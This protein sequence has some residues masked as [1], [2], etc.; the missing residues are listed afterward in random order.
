[1]RTYMRFC[2]YL[3]KYLLGI[4]MFQTDVVENIETHILHPIPVLHISYSSEMIKQ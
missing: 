4:N 3:T 2:M 1:M